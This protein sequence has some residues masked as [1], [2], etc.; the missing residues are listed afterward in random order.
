MVKKKDTSA[1]TF[2]TIGL[3]NRKTFL[4]QSSCATPEI[5]LR[6]RTYCCITTSGRGSNSAQVVSA[7]VS[8]KAF[9]GAKQRAL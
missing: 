1:G 2:S 9:H 4:Q 7:I 3:K 8:T 6:T 5:S